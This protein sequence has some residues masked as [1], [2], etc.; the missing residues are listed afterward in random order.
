[1]SKT[2]LFPSYNVSLG[3]AVEIVKFRLD[4]PDIAIKSK[5]IAIDLVANMETHNCITKSDL[6][7]ALR[8]IF[9]HYEF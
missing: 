6:V 5:I 9:R 8:W 1:M 2:I 3:E 7:S 4:S